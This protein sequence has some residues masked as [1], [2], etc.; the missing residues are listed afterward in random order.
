MI[1][2]LLSKV[3]SR[4]QRIKSKNFLQLENNYQSQ[5]K[6]QTREEKEY[7]QALYQNK[8]IIRSFIFGEPEQLTLLRKCVQQDRCPEKVLEYSEQAIWEL[9]CKKDYSNVISCVEAVFPYVER[10]FSKDNMSIGHISLIMAESCLIQGDYV[11]T[12]LYLN[13]AEDSFFLNEEE[14]SEYETFMKYY[15]SLKIGQ[16]YNKLNM[17]DKSFFY[18]VLCLKTKK[19]S[20]LQ[21]LPPC[22][23]ILNYYV[24]K[25]DLKEATDF[26]NAILKS[27]S[28]NNLLQKCKPQEIESM[29]EIY[30]IM[31]DLEKN[32]Q[33]QYVLIDQFLL[34]LSIIKSN[35]Q[36]LIEMLNKQKLK[37]Q[38]DLNN[39][40]DLLNVLGFYGQKAKLEAY[41]EQKQQQK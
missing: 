6:V 37:I 9:Y 20:F 39:Y 23:L 34:L 18:A 35:D 22:Q 33:R 25:K 4:T 26:G 7:Q 40:K 29:C 13:E 12:I 41:P 24:T 8:S 5:Q 27:L 19:L 28:F 15:Y 32:Q 31:I 38:E 11:R 21:K 30:K 14:L 16:L 36:N 1:Q 2:K 3:R 17:I 10:E